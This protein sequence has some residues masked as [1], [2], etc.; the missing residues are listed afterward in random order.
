MERDL[1]NWNA[2]VA[3]GRTREIRLARLAEVPVFFK[4]QVKNHVVTMFKIKN[5]VKRTG[6][7]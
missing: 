1:G 3:L 5:G 4:E 6:G 7:K 2:Y